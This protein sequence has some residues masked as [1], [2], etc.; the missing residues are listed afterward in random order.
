MQKFRSISGAMG[1][2]YALLASAA[3]QAVLIPFAA[4]AQTAPAQDTAGSAASETARP[5]ATQDIVV[6]ATRREER[7][8]DIPLSIRSEENTSELQSLMP[9]SYAVLCLEKKNIHKHTPKP[10]KCNT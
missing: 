7:L 10:K 8:I 2:R 3:S 4:Q 6:T 9:I 1:L 5:D